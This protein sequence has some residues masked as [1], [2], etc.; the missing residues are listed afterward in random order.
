MFRSKRSDP[1]GRGFLVDVAT[2]YGDWRVEPG[3]V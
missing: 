3:S 1:G 2:G